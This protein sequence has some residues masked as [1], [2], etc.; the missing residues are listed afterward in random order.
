MSGKAVSSKDVKGI[1]GQNKIA[2]MDLDNLASGT[3]ILRIIT[4]TISNDQKIIK[5]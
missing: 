3:Y 5:F 2:F 4:D 1:K